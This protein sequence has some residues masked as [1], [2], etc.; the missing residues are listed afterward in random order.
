VFNWDKLIENTRKNYVAIFS[1][2]QKCNYI[3]EDNLLTLYTGNKFY[4]KK[5][6]DVRYS[7]LLHKSLNE[8][9]VF[10]LDIHTIPTAQPPKDSQAA[11]VAAIM[12]G[13][14]EVAVEDNGN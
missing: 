12:G 10:G 2:L 1:V 7:S 11:A 14:E 8:V 6:D 3:L 9:G 13:G 5:L 4:K